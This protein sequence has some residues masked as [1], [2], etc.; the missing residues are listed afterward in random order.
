ME[1]M[2]KR[3]RAGEPRGATPG[4]TTR[5]H[6]GRRARTLAARRREAKPITNTYSARGDAYFVD[7]LMREAGPIRGSVM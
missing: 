4:D 2:D 3:S 1:K 6:R 5:A 7:R